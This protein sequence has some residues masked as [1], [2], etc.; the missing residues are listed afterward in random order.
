MNNINIKAVVFDFNG[1]L[2]WDTHLH[3]QAWDEF[4]SEH[5]ILITDE[6]KFKYLHGKTNREILSILFKTDLSEELFEKYNHEK[7]VIYQQLC[8]KS[9]LDFAPGAIDFIEFLAANKIDYAIATSSGINNVEFYLSYLGI[10]RWFPRERIIY[11]HGR[12]KSKPDPEIFNLAIKTLKKNPE[13]VLV[14]EDSYAGIKSA[15]QAGAGKIIIVNSG[16]DDYSSF[17]YQVITNFDM[18]DR[19]IFI[20]R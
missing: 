9:N 1:T 8:R 16:D 12:M 4:L 18:V 2:F 19:R 13:D 7:E 6:E 20:T 5:N 3:N 15:E 17:N 11:N 10:G 14:F